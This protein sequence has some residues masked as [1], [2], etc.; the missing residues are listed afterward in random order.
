MSHLEKHT[1]IA[2]SS[3]GSNASAP[4]IF[5]TAEKNTISSFIQE[6]IHTPPESS[7]PEESLIH[8][9][10][11]S[12]L[13]PPVPVN[14]HSMITR[15]KTVTYDWFVHQ[16]DVSN[17][18]LHGHLKEDVYMLQLPGF[19]DPSKP[20]HVC[21]LRKS[22]YGLKQAPR[23]W[24]E[25]FYNAILSLGFSSSYSD[26]SLFIKRDTSITFIL[27]Y[28][29]DIIITGSSIIECKSIISQLQTMFPVKDLG[30][31]H[32]FLGIE[33][34]KSDKGL[35]L[36]H[37]KY[38]LN[39]LKKTDMLGAKP[40]ATPVSTSKLDHFGTLLS[41][42]TSY[43]STVGA[44]QYLTWTRPDLAFAVNQVCQ[45]MHSP[46]TIHL[47]AVK[48]ILRYLKGTVD[49][50]LWFTK[51]PQCLTAWSDADWA[52]CP[53]DRRS[54]S[55]YCVFLG[56]NLISWSAKKQAMVAR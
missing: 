30:D 32:Y 37:T 38:A 47:Q 7:S 41:D 12:P 53:V 55:G 20:H 35:L 49:S 56:S 1:S 43:R 11:S 2:A 27:V 25:A 42:P 40:C 10:Q 45:Y 34:H 22:L 4:S 51:G 31:I 17:A 24:Y 5:S 9:P 26:T 3:E 50:R 46:R 23:A 36:H 6:S 13:Q 18:F 21:K 29:D 44:L 8:L 39:L 14:T 33:V 48:R 19:V 52:G 54:T 15:A 28:V 16:L